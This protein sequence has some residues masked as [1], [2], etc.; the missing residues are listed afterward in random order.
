[1]NDVLEHIPED[2]LEE[3]RREL[4]AHGMSE[5]DVMLPVVRTVINAAY[6]AGQVRGQRQAGER[7][8]L[9][10]TATYDVDMVLTKGLDW[11]SG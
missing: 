9:S 1:M 11:T 5:Q 10:R 4:R 8:P 6:I 2:V 3:V 7:Q